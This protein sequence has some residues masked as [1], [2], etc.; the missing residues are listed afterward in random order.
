MN[1]DLKISA[2]MDKVFPGTESTYSNYF[3]QELG[4]I[5]NALDNV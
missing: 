5:T 2:R 4:I 1:P 3:F